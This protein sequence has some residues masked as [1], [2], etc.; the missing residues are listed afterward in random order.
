MNLSLFLGL[1]WLSYGVWE[2]D[3]DFGWVFLDCF[4]G[5]D[6]ILLSKRLKGFG[7]NTM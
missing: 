2:G 4:R 5:I 3:S 7:F 6:I 1:D